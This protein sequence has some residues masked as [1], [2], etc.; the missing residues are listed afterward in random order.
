MCWKDPTA[1][2]ADQLRGGGEVSEVS[3]VVDY[4]DARFAAVGGAEAF[5]L[6]APKDAKKVRYFVLP[7][8]PPPSKLLGQ[9]VGEFKFQPAAGADVT[10]ESLAGKVVVLA[11][12]SDDARHK[13]HLQAIDALAKK[14]SG[15]EK[16]VV[17][18][19]CADAGATPERLKKLGEE[20][21]VT[22]PLLRDGEKAGGETF[23]ITQV[24]ALVVLD[25]EATMHVFDV[26]DPT[27]IAEQLPPAIERLLKGE[28][29]AGDLL[30]QVQVEHDSYEQQLATAAA[31]KS[32]TVVPVPAAVTAERTEPRKLQLE[33]RWAATLAAPGNFCVAEK[34][35][36]GAQL[37]VCEGFRTVVE[38]SNTGEVVARH[39]LVLP[40]K[41]AISNLLTA[42]GAQ[43]KRFFAASAHLAPQAFVFDAAWKPI[44]AYPPADEKHEGVRDIALADLGGDGTPE[45]YVGFWSLLG[46]HAVN[47]EG[48][49]LWT[50]RTVPTALALAVTPKN[51]IGLRE[52]LAV[53]DRGQVVRLH[54]F[55]D[56]DKPIELPGRAQYSL[57]TGRF[58]GERP[59]TYCGLAYQ[60]DG[61]MTAV[62]LEKE[63]KEAWSFPLAPG[64]YENQIEPITSGHLLGDATGYW[65][66]AGPD[67]AVCVIS[68]DGAFVDVFNYGERLSGI[69]VATLD[70]EPLLIVSAGKKV[71]AWR[72]TLPKEEKKKQ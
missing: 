25:G 36:G 58:Q 41:A 4:R 37:F 32:S 12:F 9:K 1:A 51:D 20:W 21:Q 16:L 54:Q 15:R 22:V 7:P 65:V 45:L 47:L 6:E 23:G 64:A 57:I 44:A 52:L 31:A 26:F 35:G 71:E 59:T 56:A 38:L 27:T 2:L 67:G 29:L 24:P 48:K 69:T 66:L 50:N 19:V 70:K 39:E 40:E 55:G 61:R 3:L 42:E 49:Q 62:A 30:K 60:A 8:A 72:V 11:F 63:L 53:G 33:R 13:P 14:L 34:A 18:G 46:V 68:D 10:R 17:Y 28:N 43:G 5:A